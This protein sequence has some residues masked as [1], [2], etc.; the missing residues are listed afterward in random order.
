MSE[1]LAVHYQWL[2]AGHIFSVIAFM[3]GMLYL[4]R[5]YVYHVN[6]APGGELD[7]ALKLQEVRLLRVITNPAAG[8]ALV[9][10]ILMFIAN[11]TLLSQGWMHVKFAALVLIFGAHGYY[12][13]ARKKFAD[14]KNTRSE[15]F[16]RILNEIPAVLAIIIVIMAVVEPF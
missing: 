3:A 10:G 7:E 16:W 4:P 5:L 13:A 1:F 15:K 8:A 9:F 2:R 14:G 12:A 6:A 11:P